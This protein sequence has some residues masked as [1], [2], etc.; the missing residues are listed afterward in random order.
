M[1]YADK[2]YRC[3]GYNFKSNN[4]HLL[5]EVGE[6]RT[7]S[8]WLKIIFPSKDDEDIEAY[9][10]GDTAK[11]ITDYLQMAMGIRLVKER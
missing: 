5:G 1:K 4:H 9:F 6:V 11:E 2:L 7:M 8:E 3:S 10:S